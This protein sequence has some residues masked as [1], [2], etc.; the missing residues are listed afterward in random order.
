M[1]THCVIGIKLGNSVASSYCHIDGYLK[2]VGAKLLMY[3][4]TQ[5]EAR[6]LSTFGEM[7]N[8]KV[9]DVETV[10]AIPELDGSDGP[11]RNTPLKEYA[12]KAFKERAAAFVYLFKNNRWYVYK[13]NGFIPLTFKMIDK[14]KW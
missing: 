6:K 14:S 11:A 2:G 3:V 13:G 4:R 1:S 7:N 12:S 9:W 8:L 10:K 5:E